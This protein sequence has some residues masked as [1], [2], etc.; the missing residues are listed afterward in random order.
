[1]TIK[2]VIGIVL[3][4]LGFVAMAR[5]GVWWNREKTVIDAGPLQVHTTEREGF[6][7]SPV[8][9]MACLVGGIVLLAVPDRRRT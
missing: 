1:M 5:G 6:P 4:V 2:K 3:I 9:G 7:L 8:L